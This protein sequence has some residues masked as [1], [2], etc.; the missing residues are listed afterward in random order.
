[1]VK[2]NKKDTNKKNS[3]GNKLPFK[4][5][6]ED[7]SELE[8]DSL[9]T[10]YQEIATGMK[11]ISAKLQMIKSTINKE[12]GDDEDLDIL[13]KGT[14]GVYKELIDEIANITKAH[15]RSTSDGKVQFFTGRVNTENEKEFDHYINI[16]TTYN[17]ILEKISSF[18]STSIL[19]LMTTFQEKLLEKEK[20]EKDKGEEKNESK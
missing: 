13:F 6:D 8:W 5:V 18:A 7:K 19:T 3:K 9:T 16:V 14:L 2:K 11:E 10:L 17:S 12:L 20:A 4:L 1:M 15:S